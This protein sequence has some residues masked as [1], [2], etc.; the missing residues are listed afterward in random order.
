MDG[1]ALL[2]LFEP[3]QI[4]KDGRDGGALAGLR[5][6]WQLVQ[7]RLNKKKVRASPQEGLAPAPSLRKEK[8]CYAMAVR[9]APVF[10]P[11]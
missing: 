1:N 9:L 5:G 8:S 10:R 2:Q 4:L 11:P 7:K 3:A 6:E